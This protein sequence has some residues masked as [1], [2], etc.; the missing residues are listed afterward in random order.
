MKPRSSKLITLIL[1]IAI[2]VSAIE[3]ETKIAGLIQRELKE[4]AEVF[5]KK[6]SINPYAQKINLST[7]ILEKKIEAV[8][9]N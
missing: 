5:P 4:H 9:S 6:P 7:F 8:V 3:W 1:L 2:F